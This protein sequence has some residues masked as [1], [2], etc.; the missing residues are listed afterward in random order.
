MK[1]PARV[2][3]KPEVAPTRY[4][5]ATLSAKAVPALVD[6]TKGPMRGNSL[7]GAHPSVNGMMRALIVAHTC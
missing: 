5:A 7:N 1:T 3:T 6:N 2:K 4:T